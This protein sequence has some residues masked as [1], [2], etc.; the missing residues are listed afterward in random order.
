MYIHVGHAC[1][2]V[3]VGGDCLVCVGVC[4]HAITFLR[5]PLCVCVYMWLPLCTH[6]HALLLESV[7][8]C[9]C[10]GGSSLALWCGVCVCVCGGGW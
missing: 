8:V 1:A 7:G 3:F 5:L 10:V 4:A 2:C 6:V 9:V